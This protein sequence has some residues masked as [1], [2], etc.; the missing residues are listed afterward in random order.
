MADQG[1]KINWEFLVDENFRVQLQGHRHRP[2]YSSPI[3]PFLLAY[4]NHFL[5]YQQ[6]HNRPHAMEYFMDIQ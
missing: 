6:R 3:G 4:I 5:A 1:E 2:E